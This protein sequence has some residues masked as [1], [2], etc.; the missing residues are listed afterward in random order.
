MKERRMGRISGMVARLEKRREFLSLGV[1]KIGTRSMCVTRY[2]LQ[3][4]TR[5]TERHLGKL[6]AEL[7]AVSNTRGTSPSLPPS[8][9]P[10]VLFLFLSLF[11]YLA[12]F[13]LYG[14]TDGHSNSPLATL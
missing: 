9:L 8:F 6:R 4:V 7:A 14:E 5:P 11:L 10:S 1:R 13:L 12:I 3:L 2:R